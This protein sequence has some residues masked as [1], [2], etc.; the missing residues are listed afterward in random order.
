MTE[1]SF[2]ETRDESLDE[3]FGRVVD[4][5]R[6]EVHAHCYRML[7]SAFD[8]DDAVQE[9]LLRAWRS[10]ERFDGRSSVRTWVYTIATRVCIDASTSRGRRALP[11]DL[12]PS[13]EVGPA[14][15]A[16]HDDVRW[17]TPY[18]DPVDASERRNT[19]ELAFSAA[20]QRL[21]G[22]QRAAFL[23]SDVVGYSAP[24][25]AEMMST[26]TA[27]V[28][29]ALA[30]ARRALGERSGSETAAPPASSETVAL[31]RRFAA[32]LADADLDGF[33]D[34]LTPDVTWEMP[35]LAEWYEGRRAVAAFAQAVPMTQCPSWRTR[36]LVANGHPAVAFF[37]GDGENPKH[38]PWSITVLVPRGDRIASIYSFLDARLFARFGLPES[39]Q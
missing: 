38:R 30:R 17:I 14:H 16:P 13:T 33:V 23:L 25:V 5:L 34:L 20:L 9:T 27:S 24:E 18:P 1:I 29:S 19:I 21:N 26:T 10:F 7:G 36:L 22:N 11:V 2:A 4:P 37:L 12:G 6:R 3:Q 35:P 39:V 31:A 32:A 28:H 8:A 15:L